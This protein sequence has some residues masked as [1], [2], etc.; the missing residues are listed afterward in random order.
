MR[1]VRICR[2]DNYTGSWCCSVDSA[3]EL[4]CWKRCDAE[5]E[6]EVRDGLEYKILMPRGE[7]YGTSSP[8]QV[9]SQQCDRGRSHN[10]HPAGGY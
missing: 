9:P 8:S 1:L 10:P 6:V 5:G 2:N 4:R 7:W 3:S